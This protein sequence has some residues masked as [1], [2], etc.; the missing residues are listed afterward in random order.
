[1]S[2]STHRS[3]TGFIL[4]EQGATIIDPA[5]I[6][7]IVTQE[8]QRNALQWNTCAGEGGAKGKDDNCSVVS[9]ME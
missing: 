5:D 9:S 3:S 8:P 6:P 4:K 7:S 1:M 2:K